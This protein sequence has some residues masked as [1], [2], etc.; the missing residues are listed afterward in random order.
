MTDTKE[1]LRIVFM[2]TPEIS[3]DILSALLQDKY[4]IVGVYTQPDKRVGRKQVLQ[5]SPV[6]TLAEKNSIPV[7]DPRRLDAEAIENLRE[8]NPD[9]IVLI[10]YGKILPQV[11]LDLPRL[12]AVN[13]H[14][15]LLPKF[16][17]PSPIQSALLNGEK[18][19]G[20]TIMLMDVG[21]DTGH[22]LQQEQIDIDTNETYFELEKKLTK[23]SV[24]LLLETLPKLISGQAKPRKQ[25]DNDATYCKMI[26]KEEGQV[27]WNQSAENIFNKYRAF[28][29]WPGI[30]TSWNDKHLK[31][32][33]V[34]LA[35]SSFAEYKN[36]EI[37]RIENSIFVQ[38]ASGAI[39]LKEVQLEGKPV[40]KILNFSNGYKNFIGSILS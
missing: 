9:L 10:A 13:I 25:N 14:P 12:G 20:T 28:A 18:V 27:D 32:N 36:G 38:T 8:M 17:G 34:A 39:E 3:A 11:V 5:K 33:S 21:I 1:N 15:S 2:G 16:R 37:F 24:K 19:T 7:F 29:S 4:N 30:F 23:L 40:T 22:I 6:K 31:L 26:R 35:T